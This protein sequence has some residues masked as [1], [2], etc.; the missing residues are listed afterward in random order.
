MWFEKNEKQDL[1]QETFKK[2]FWDK[3]T[4]MSPDEKNLLSE[5]GNNFDSENKDLKQAFNKTIDDK[6]NKVLSNLWQE[7]KDKLK[8]L[9]DGMLKNPNDLKEMAKALSEINSIIWTENK[10][11]A[12]QWENFAKAQEQAAKEK[13]KLQEFMDE[14]SKM[15]TKSRELVK[16]NQEKA[17]QAN[18]KWALEQKQVGQKAEANLLKEWPEWGNEKQS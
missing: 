18:S 10:E 9:K 3:M 13:T 15:L 17:K 8:S 5:V 2:E 1:N 14:F 6:V 11:N 7:D 4:D 12:I 16:Q